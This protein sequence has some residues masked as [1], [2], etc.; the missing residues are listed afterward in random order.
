MSVTITVA[1]SF[2]SNSALARPMPLAPPVTNAT[3]PF[4][5]SAMTCSSSL[6]KRTGEALA[7]LR[8]K[9]LQRGIEGRRVIDV[10]GMPGI[11]DH[12]LVAIRDLRGHVVGGGEERR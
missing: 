10:R 7:H 4:T 2:A 12:R 9:I 8:Q 11:R 3:F 6:L 5:R 1:P